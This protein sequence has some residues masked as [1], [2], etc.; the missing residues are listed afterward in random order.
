MQ[1]HSS[2][3]CVVTIVDHVMLQTAL[4]AKDDFAELCMHVTF[5][6]LCSAD[7]LSVLMWTV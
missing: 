6:L 1:A 7:I 5:T 4:G 2:T 3:C